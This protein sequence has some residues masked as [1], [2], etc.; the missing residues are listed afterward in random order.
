MRHQIIEKTLGIPGDYQYRAIRSRN[1]L[2]SNWHRNKWLVVEKLIDFYRPQTALDLGTGSGN[3]ELNFSS[4]LK[5]IVGIDYNHDALAFLSSELKRKKITNVKL[6]NQDIA[7]LFKLPLGKFDLILMVDVLEHLAIN[8]VYKFVANVGNN[9][10][11]GGKI[12]I[13]TPNYAGL[14]PIAEKLIDHFTSLPGLESIQHITKFSLKLLN[15][16]FRQNKFEV[17]CSG[18]FNT[19]SYL[20]PS[21]YFSFHLCELEMKIPFLWGNLI[22][23]VL[24]INKKP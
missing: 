9:L 12:I 5:S 21:Q 11:P 24:E 23:A 20:I 3:F 6:I 10:S 18:T 4:R 2:Q 7:D 8:S 22:Y 19:V 17:V 16:V 15:R 14:W 13:I 1:F